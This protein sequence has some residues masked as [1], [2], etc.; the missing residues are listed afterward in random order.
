MEIEFTLEKIFSNKRHLRDMLKEFAILKSF[1]LETIEI[2]SSRV[3][4]RW[5]EKGTWSVH[6]SIDKGVFFNQKT[7]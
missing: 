2:D 7:L 6:A 1:E 5:F 3:T 4:A